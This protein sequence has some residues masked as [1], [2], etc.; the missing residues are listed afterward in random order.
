MNGALH[1]ESLPGDEQNAFDFL[2]LKRG[3]ACSDVPAIEFFSSSNRYA[4]DDGATN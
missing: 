2:R 3:F 4:I 1:S